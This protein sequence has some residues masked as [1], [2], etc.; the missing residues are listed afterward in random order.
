MVNGS[1]SLIKEIIKCYNNNITV[2][3]VFHEKALNLYRLYL[4]V[5]ECEAIKNFISN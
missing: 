2:D 3:S 4:C 1:Y 5:V